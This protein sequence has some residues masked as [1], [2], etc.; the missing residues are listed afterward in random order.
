MDSLTIKKLKEY[1]QQDEE[2][3][4]DQ[5]FKIGE[6]VSRPLKLTLLDI[7]H[8]AEKHYSDLDK[9]AASIKFELEQK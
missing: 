4:P 6:G 3:Q 1:E 8:S 7:V 9:R 5:I 2:K